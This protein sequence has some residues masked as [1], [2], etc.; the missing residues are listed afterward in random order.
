MEIETSFR[1]AFLQ[2]ITP[3]PEYEC[4]ESGLCSIG[5]VKVS[6]C[7]RFTGGRKKRAVD[8]GSIMTI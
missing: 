1:E 6:S 2:A 7:E 3:L 5:D 4:F 8:S